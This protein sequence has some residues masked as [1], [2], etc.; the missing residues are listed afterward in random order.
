MILKQLPFCQEQGSIRY[1]R[2]HRGRDHGHDRGRDR[3]HDRGH[4][5]RDRDCDHEVLKLIV[6]LKASGGS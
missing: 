3:G 2:A 1:D 4:G 5:H 6:R